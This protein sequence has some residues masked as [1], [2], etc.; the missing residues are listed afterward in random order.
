MLHLGNTLLQIDDSKPTYFQLMLH[1]RSVH[2][3]CPPCFLPSW[4]T[5]AEDAP[6]IDNIA[7]HHGRGKW[8]HGRSQLRSDISHFALYWP[9]FMWSCPIL[10]C[11]NVC[12]SYCEMPGYVWKIILSTSPLAGQKMSWKGIEFLETRTTWSHGGELPDRRETLL[13]RG[14]DTDASTLLLHLHGSVC[15]GPEQGREGWGLFPGVQQIEW[16]V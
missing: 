1:A 14:T 16:P 12:F 3:Y 5:Q 6:P 7:R 9:K 15:H 13:K 4:R 8:Q 10:T 11:Q 2:I